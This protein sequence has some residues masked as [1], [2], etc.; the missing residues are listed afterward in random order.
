MDSLR[1]LLDGLPHSLRLRSVARTRS[2]PSLGVT[3]RLR[4]SGRGRTAFG[5][6]GS[7]PK[8]SVHLSRLAARVG[9]D[10]PPLCIHMPMADG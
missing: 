2:P 7:V 4:R 6:L 9:S 10:Q 5:L 3:N 1:P 8:R